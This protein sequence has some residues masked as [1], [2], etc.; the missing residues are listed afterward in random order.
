MSLTTLFLKLLSDI[1]STRTG[2]RGA[3]ISPKKKQACG[4]K[5]KKSNRN[6]NIS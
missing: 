5:K 2:Q 6:A 3:P 4:R 1:N